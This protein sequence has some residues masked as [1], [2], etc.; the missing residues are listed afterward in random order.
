MFKTL[1]QTEF[2]ANRM[3]LATTG[4]INLFFLLLMGVW[5]S[6]PLDSY[7]GATAVAFIINL[8]IL[9]I[10]Q[11]DQR[12]M[13]LYAQLPVSPGQVFW[14]CWLF[15]FFWLGLQCLS[16]L[17][18]SLLFETG[19]SAENLLLIGSTA[20][21]LLVGI[22]LVSLLLDLS[23][24]EPRRWQWL[25]MGLIVGA[26]GLAVVLDWQ[27]GL[28]APSESGMALATSRGLL[29]LAVLFLLLFTADLITWR[30]SAHFLK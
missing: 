30:R 16:W 15:V 21:G 13:R 14:A 1:T 9:A 2:R 18:Y 12:R 26:V 8:S 10:N 23:R 3:M 17:L 11:S 19:R 5:D 24:I 29:A 27:P 25:F 6:R 28:Y 7:V 20:L 4:V 22:T